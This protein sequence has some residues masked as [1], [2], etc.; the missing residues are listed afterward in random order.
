MLRDPLDQ[1]AQLFHHAARPDELAGRREPPHLS[2]EGFVLAEERG[3]LRGAPHDREDLVDLERL[4]EKVEGAGLHRVHGELDRGDPCQQ[5]HRDRGI[6]F[7][8]R[9]EDFEARAVGHLL[10]GHDDVDVAGGEGLARL[11]NAVRLQDL[12]RQILEDGA[13]KLADGRLVVDDEQA[14]HGESIDTWLVE[15]GMPAMRRMKLRPGGRRR[16]AA[17]NNVLRKWVCM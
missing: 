15:S 16:G 2:L 1:S 5:D 7:A 17:L 11:G 13:Q 8:G 6:G 12:G 4:R 10:I 3:P 14:R 9:R